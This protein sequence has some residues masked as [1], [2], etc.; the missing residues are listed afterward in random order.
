M[1]Q[2]LDLTENALSDTLP[3]SWSWALTSVTALLLSSMRLSGTLPEGQ[4][5]TRGSQVLE[6]RN[7]SSHYSANDCYVFL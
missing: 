1:L 4:D 7:G 3:Q 6:P 2:T 5:Q